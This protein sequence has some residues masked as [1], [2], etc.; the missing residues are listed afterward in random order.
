MRPCKVMGLTDWNRVQPILQIIFI[1]QILHCTS[2]SYEFLKSRTIFLTTPHSPCPGLDLPSTLDLIW[3]PWLLSLHYPI[4]QMLVPILL[5][6]LK[7]QPQRHKHPASI[8]I[9]PTPLLI[10]GALIACPTPQLQQS[11]NWVSNCQFPQTLPWNE[12][13]RWH[14]ASA[15]REEHQHF[16]T[17]FQWWVNKGNDSCCIIL[18]PLMYTTIS[19][20]VPFR[21]LRMKGKRLKSE[22]NP[23]SIIQINIANNFNNWTTDTARWH[24]SLLITNGGR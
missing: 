21:I 2:S 10:Y 19:K 8:Q 24:F 4:L 15:E 18:H 6:H 13:I 3:Q 5:F 9:A 20:Q 16:G 14:I 23:C 12:V 22:M 17:C 1:M 7:T 11:C